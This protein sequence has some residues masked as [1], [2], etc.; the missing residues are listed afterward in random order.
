M[1]NGYP[2]ITFDGANYMSIE[3]EN[4]LDSGDG[5]SIFAVIRKINDEIQDG[6]MIVVKRKHWNVWS[7]DPPLS[8]S[9]IRY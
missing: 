3:D 5:L 1:I 8:P 2:W 4:N 9:H 7:Y 6:R